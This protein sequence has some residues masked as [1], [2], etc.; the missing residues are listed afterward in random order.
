M[1]FRIIKNA[2]GK[3]KVQNKINFFSPWEDVNFYFDDYGN[4][5]DREEFIKN[6]TSHLCVAQE[7]MQNLIQREQAVKSKNFEIIEETTV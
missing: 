6:E 3:Y 1:K 5:Y 4:F 2:N 7:K